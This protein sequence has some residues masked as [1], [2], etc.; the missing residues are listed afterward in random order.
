MRTCE[1]VVLQQASEL[2]QCRGAGADSRDRAMPT[3]SRSAWLSYSASSNASSA[4][5]YHCSKQYVLSILVTRIGCRPT[6]PL[7]GYSG[8]I[9]A[10]SRA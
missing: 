6:R 4:R 9:T 8:S 7:L 2:Q 10:I 1:I 5:P 3:K